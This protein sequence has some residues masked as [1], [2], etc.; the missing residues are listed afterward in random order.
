MRVLTCTL[1]GTVELARKGQFRSKFAMCAF[2]GKADITRTCSD[3]R[4]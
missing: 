2:G 4:F 1:K 3:V